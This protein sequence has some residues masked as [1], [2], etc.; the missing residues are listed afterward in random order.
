MKPIAIDGGRGGR[1]KGGSPCVPTHPRGVS[2]STR[3]VVQGELN[4]PVLVVDGYNFLH[5]WKALAQGNGVGGITEAH[6]MHDAREVVVR[7]LEVYSQCRGVRVVVVFDA[8]HSPQGGSRCASVD[9]AGM[10]KECNVGHVGCGHVVAVAATD[11]G[12]LPRTHA[13]PTTRHLCR[14]TTPAAVDVVYSSDCEA[15]SYIV[16][17]VKR[18]L[19]H[20]APYVLVA[21]QDGVLSDCVRGND[22]AWTM[23]HVLLHKE[24]LRV[25]VGDGHSMCGLC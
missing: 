11:H 23:T 5:Q 24:L 16:A 13:A 19:E 15:D 18:L 14:Y 2:K 8:M 21:T 3:I 22:K 10:R 20:G 17:E 9:D 1:C 25:C 7:A 6:S 12:Y 4:P